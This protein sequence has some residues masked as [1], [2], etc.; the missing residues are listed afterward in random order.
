MI[1]VLSKVELIIIVKRRIRR[2]GTIHPFINPTPQPKRQPL[3]PLKPRHLLFQHSLQTN[4]SPLALI[5]LFTSR[6]VLLCS[7]I[8]N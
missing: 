1:G 4:Q 2:D 8:Q 5:Q 3:I 6:F 7:Q